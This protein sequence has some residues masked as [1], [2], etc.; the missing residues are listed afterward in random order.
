MSLFTGFTTTKNTPTP[1]KRNE[2][3]SLM[4]TPSRKLLSRTVNLSSLKSA[5]PGI[6]T[7]GVR[8]FVTNEVMT[9]PN[10]APMATPT[11]RSKT[12]PRR[13]KSLEVLEHLASLPLREP[14]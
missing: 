8:M 10:A 6:A 9:L 4:K 11:A 7:S 2:T 3:T 12:L 5:F 13:M 1:I 14:L